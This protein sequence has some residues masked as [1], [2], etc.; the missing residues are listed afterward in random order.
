MGIKGNCGND[1]NLI[2][3]K[4]KKATASVRNNVTMNQTVYFLF[5]SIGNQKENFNV[6][7]LE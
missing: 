7:N 3:N 2:C 6:L 4:R 1:Q 5:H